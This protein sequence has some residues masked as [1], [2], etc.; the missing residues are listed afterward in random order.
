MGHLKMLYFKTL[1]GGMGL[2]RERWKTSIGNMK[3]SSEK[4]GALTVSFSMNSAPS[5]G[6]T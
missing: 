1:K 2:S 4:I 3:I 5:P 6:Y